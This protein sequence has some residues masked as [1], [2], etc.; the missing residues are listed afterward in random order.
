MP[1]TK[2]IKFGLW[3]MC[4]IKTSNLPVPF[5]RSESVELELI[6]HILPCKYTTHNSSCHGNRAKHNKYASESSNN[7]N[8][9]CF[10][11]DAGA[12]T[13]SHRNSG[14]CVKQSYEN[15]TAEPKRMT[16]KQAFNKKSF[17]KGKDVRCIS[18]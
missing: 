16:E 14:N 17:R 10:E 11:F 2:S 13:H 4:R 5:W 15:K 1:S 8:C 12:L 3:I 7:T 18:N 6:S 9:N